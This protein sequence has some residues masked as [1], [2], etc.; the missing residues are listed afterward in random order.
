MFLNNTTLL[1]IFVL[2]VIASFIGFGIRDRNPGVILLG[3][4]FLAMLIA[5][6]SKAIE[7][8]G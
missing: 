4:G 1:V 3:L 7:I 2:G 5:I 8:F 6:I